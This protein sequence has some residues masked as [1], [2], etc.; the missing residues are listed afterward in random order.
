MSASVLSKKEEFS[1]LWNDD[2]PGV[3]VV[4]ATEIIYPLLQEFDM[5]RIQKIPN[6]EQ[7][8]VIF[9]MD[10]EHFFLS[11]KAMKK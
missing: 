2:Y 4:D 6:P 7:N 8:S 10:E 11:I 9:D 3:Q 5:G 1:R